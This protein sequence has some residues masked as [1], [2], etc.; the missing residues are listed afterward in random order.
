MTPARREVARTTSLVGAD[1]NVETGR[2]GI[3]RAPLSPRTVAAGVILFGWSLGIVAFA[4]R[5][6]SR[7]TS[8]RMAEIA[9][10]VAPGATYYAAERDGQHVGFASTTVDTLARTLQFSEYRVTDAPDSGAKRRVTAQTVIRLTRGLALREFTVTS[11]SDAASRRITGWMLDD[12]TLAFSVAA[13][14]AVRDTQQVTVPPGVVLLSMV[15]MAVALGGEL[16]VGAQRIVETFD[17]EAGRRQTIHAR[18]TAE[19][20]FVL[21]DSAVYDGSR[22]KWTPAR[23]DTLSGW[24]MSIDGSTVPDVWIDE[25]GHPIGWQA[26]DGLILRRTAYELAFENWRMVRPRARGSDSSGRGNVLGMTAIRAH[27]VVPASDRGSFRVRLS[28]IPL[29][30]FDLTGWGQALASDTLRIDRATT[31]SLVPSFVLPPNDAVRQRFAAS[32]GSAPLIEADAPVIAHLANHL[33]RG[34]PNPVRAVQRIVTWMRDSI[35][36]TPSDGPPGAL[37]ALRERSGDAD[38]Q[39][40][41][42]VALARAS[43]VPARSVV[44]LLAIEGRFYPHAWAEVFVQGWVPV[45]PSLN[46]FPATPTHIRFLVDGVGALD[47]FMRA[48]EHLRVDIPPSRR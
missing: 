29:D 4:H 31:R 19:S 18:I 3:V 22:A 13:A 20:T 21:A 28:G 14:G 8:D 45:D 44:G 25:M 47:D 9:L 42:F 41:L 11:A 35:A 37:R 30:V 27:R 26:A 24:R 46:Q 32:L 36:G 15:P 40:L 34:E 12:S 5:E 38:G 2:A 10:R 33:N 43:G 48:T 1:T 16:R 23:M 7:T 17:P 39:A 6:M